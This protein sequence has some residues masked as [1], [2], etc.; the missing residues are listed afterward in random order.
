MPDQE[1]DDELLAFDLRHRAYRVCIESLT[2]A[3]YQ[4]YR[5]LWQLSDGD[6]READRLYTAF[7]DRA[8]VEI[9]ALDLPE[10]SEETK[11]QILRDIKND[12]N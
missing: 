9:T 3:L 8:L 1:T 12:K 7:Y 11:T 6:E 5:L 4:L 10:L 2:D